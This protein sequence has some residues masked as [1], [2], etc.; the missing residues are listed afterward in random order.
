[1][2]DF[3]AEVLASGLLR[4][5]TDD[6]QRA[7]AQAEAQQTAEQNAALDEQRAANLASAKTDNQLAVQ[8]IG[9]TWQALAGATRQ[10]LLPQQRAWIAKKNADCKVEAAAASIDPNDKEIARLNCDT[11]MTQERLPW[12][13]NFRDEGGSATAAIAEPASPSGEERPNDL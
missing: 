8:T 4:A 7:E 12:L 2:F 1:M 9:A 11:R 5:S 6:S 13:A 3:A 10:R